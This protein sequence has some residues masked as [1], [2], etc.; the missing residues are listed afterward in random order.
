MSGPVI[1]SIRARLARLS[2]QF[3]PAV[4]PGYP[5]RLS[6]PGYPGCLGPVI[7]STPRRIRQV[8]AGNSTLHK[9]QKL[10]ILKI[11]YLLHMLSKL[12]I[13]KTLRK[14]QKL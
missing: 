8:Q 10:Q 2:G 3:I 5:G 13:L 12:Y 1:H 4:W 14:L 7:L 6:G 9:L 11:L